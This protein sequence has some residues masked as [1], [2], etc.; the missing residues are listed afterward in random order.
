MTG[1]VL[2]IIIKKKRDYE[3]QDNTA[4]LFLELLCKTKSSFLSDAELVHSGGQKEQT[5]Q[6]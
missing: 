1:G 6:T 3:G 5:C 4:Q 2:F